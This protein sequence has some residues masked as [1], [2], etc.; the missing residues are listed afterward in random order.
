M[1]TLPC[2]CGTKFCSGTDRHERIA[3]NHIDNLGTLRHDKSSGELGAEMRRRQDDS[4]RILTEHLPF[5]GS[6]IRPLAENAL[7]AATMVDS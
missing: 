5:L 4:V 1:S 6:M 2:P 7:N 3:R